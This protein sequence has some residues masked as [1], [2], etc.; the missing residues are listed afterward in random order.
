[1]SYS[2]STKA[3]MVLEELMIQ[4]QVESDKTSNGFSVNW[5]SCFYEIGK[6]NSDGAITGVVNKETTPGFC[7]VAGSFR[8]ENT[9]KITRF[10]GS[11]K[12]QRT[13]AETAGLI[14]YHETFEP[15][16]NNDAVLQSHIQGCNFVVI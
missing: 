13:T 7:R 4:L 1:M 5:K 12:Q 10:P 14:K 6:E 11:T 15:G 16:W 3:N 2:C 9:G 8:I